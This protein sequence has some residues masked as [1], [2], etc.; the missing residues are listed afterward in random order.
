M[1]R[2]V[3]IK[4]MDNKTWLAYR[5]MGITG[6]DTGIVLGLSK[7]KSVLELYKDKRNE[8]PIEEKETNFTLWGHNLEDAIRKHFEKVNGVKVTS[9]NFIFQSDE[10]PFM[11]GNFDGIVTELDG[12]KAILEIKTSIE[13]KDSIYQQGNIP[14]EYYSQMM[15][16][17]ALS[18]FQFC[19]LACLVGG[20]KYYQFK[21]ERDDEYISWLIEREKTFW[22]CVQEGVL[23]EVDSSKATS[24]YLGEE[25]AESV[26]DEIL[27]PIEAGNIADEY[28][29]IDETI[30]SLTKE[31]DLLSNKLKLLLGEHEVGI[32]G[33]RKIKWTPVSQNRLDTEKL[34][35]ELGESYND[36]TKVSTYRKLSVA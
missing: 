13:F 4:G 23:P 24:K 10:Y 7:H 34:K 8:I 19:Y 9:P 27:L 11:I 36:Y 12:T 18:N 20:N 21:I 1:K 26:K 14:P 2:L 29:A 5:R 17:M 30:K 3:N 15:H 28:L 31:K 25:Y 32:I 16:Y 33:E 6:S 22:N 35:Q